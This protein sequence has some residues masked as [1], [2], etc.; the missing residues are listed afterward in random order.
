MNIFLIMCAALVA[1]GLCF[2]IVLCCIGF[3][4]CLDNARL[5]GALMEI[6]IGIIVACGIYVLAL[7]AGTLL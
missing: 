7:G 5:G 3:F 4:N 6:L 2:L 1:F